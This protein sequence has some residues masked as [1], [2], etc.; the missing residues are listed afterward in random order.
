LFVGNPVVPQPTFR[1]TLSGFIDRFGLPENLLAD[2]WAERWRAEQVH[3]SA[4]RFG[5]LVLDLDELEQPISHE[6]GVRSPPQVCQLS[7]SGGLGRGIGWRLGCKGM[8]LPEAAGY[9]GG[10]MAPA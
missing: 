8:A 2:I 7:L 1:L 9:D 4:E 6:F 10:P 5:K 3:A